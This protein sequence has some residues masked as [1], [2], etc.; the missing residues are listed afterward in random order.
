MTS[1]ADR[2]VLI[3]VRALIV[4]GGIVLLRC[5]REFALYL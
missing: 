5:E 1:D 4:I 3:D 2:P